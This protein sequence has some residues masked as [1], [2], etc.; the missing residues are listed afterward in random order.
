MVHDKARIGRLYVSLNNPFAIRVI[1]SA[2]LKAT[3]R[4]SS[5]SSFI[6]TTTY[7]FVCGCTETC[8]VRV[9]MYIL[10]IKAVLGSNGWPSRRE[11]SWIDG[12]WSMRVPTIN[13]ARVKLDL[14]ELLWSETE[15]RIICPLAS[16]KL[17][18]LEIQCPGSVCIVHMGPPS[19]ITITQSN[20]WLH[21]FELNPRVQRVLV[22]GC[23]E[24]K[25]CWFN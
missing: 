20:V 4:M 5:I 14:G 12:W 8:P 18:K 22:A 24:G 13:L 19:M 11:C 3:S 21:W 16:N 9:H 1:V 25:L 2:L 6:S 23:C 7:G 17:C 15:N 10:V